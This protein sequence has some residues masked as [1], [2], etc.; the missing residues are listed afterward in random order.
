MPSAQDLGNLP[1]SRS[2]QPPKQK[3]VWSTPARELRLERPLARARLR[4]KGSA[5][6]CR[7]WPFPETCACSRRLRDRGVLKRQNSLS[8]CMGPTGSM[9]EEVDKIDSWDEFDVFQ[10]D[11][12]TDHRPLSC[13]AMSVVRARGLGDYFS[14]KHF[15]SFVREIEGQY[16]E[17]PYHNRLH[18][19]DVTQSTHL[20]LAGKFSGLPAAATI[21]AAVCHD[22]GI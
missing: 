7:C 9:R 15:H 22:V 21:F 5:F 2:P 19:T 10:L 11:A 16:Q 1:S 8:M 20:M 4:R 3:A 12:V 18:A 14:L 17:R 13:V 6:L